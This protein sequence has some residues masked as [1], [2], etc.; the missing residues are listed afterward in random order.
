MAAAAATVLVSGTS[1]MPEAQAIGPVKLAL[2]DPE[3]HAVTCP[4]KTQVR[5][6]QRDEQSRVAIASSAADRMPS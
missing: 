5:E 3:Y 1:P 4:P 6:D 2:S